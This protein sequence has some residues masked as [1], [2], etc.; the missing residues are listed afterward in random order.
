[1]IILNQK[2]DI[3]PPKAI[4]IGRGTGLGNPDPIGIGG[5]REEVIAS[6]EHYL[7]K[8]IDRRNPIILLKLLQLTQDSILSC[9]CKPAA[10]H[11]DIIEKVWNARVKDYMSERTLFYAGIGA[12]K[13]VPPKIL[14]LMTKLAARLDDLGFTMRSGGANGSDDAFERGATKKEIY[15]PWQGFNKRNS[16]FDSATSEAYRL[17]ELIYPLPLTDPTTRAFMGRN[18]HQVLGRTLR[19]PSDFVVC[20]TKDG[21]ETAAKRDRGTG[22]TGQAIE[23]A[24]WFK[25]PVFNLC[26]ANAMERITEHVMSHPMYQQ[27]IEADSR[28]GMH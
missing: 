14:A 12:R 7:N 28:M 3:I 13:N 4:Y 24:S 2:I 15:L 5:T 10:C 21:V 6:Y 23:L 19:E 25:I 18:S 9:S 27:K 1:V 26:N 22:G 16:D 11:G 20:W 17:A 8:E